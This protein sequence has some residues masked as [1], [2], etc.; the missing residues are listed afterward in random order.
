MM[1]P[2]G[3]LALCALAVIAGAPGL[4]AEPL[5]PI[6]AQG[7]VV[8]EESCAACHGHDAAGDTGSD[9]RA[10]PRHL[11]A[12]AIKGSDDMPEIDLSKAELD[13][14]VAYLAH[15]GETIRD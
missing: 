3:F 13:A 12:W 2:R 14:V 4:C 10:A 8:F 1:T 7:Q 9:I 6:Q 11:V 15:L 5:A